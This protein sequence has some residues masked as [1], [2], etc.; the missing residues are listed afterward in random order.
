MINLRDPS[1]MVYDIV[2]IERKA[3]R[4][5]AETFAQTIAAFSRWLHH[6]IRT[7]RVRSRGAHTA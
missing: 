3:R 5:R 6:V 1:K 2:E 7:L 4:L